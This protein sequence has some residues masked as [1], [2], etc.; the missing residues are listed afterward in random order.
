MAVLQNTLNTVSPLKF[1]EK[2][3][4]TKVLKTALKNGATDEN[5]RNDYKDKKGKK[6]KGEKV[7]VSADE[8][9]SNKDK[10]AKKSKPK[11]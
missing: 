6:R 10:A 5:N 8:A 9:T 3:P 4:G 11:K 2:Y 1:N 7:T